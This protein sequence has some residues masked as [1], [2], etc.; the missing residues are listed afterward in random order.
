[1]AIKFRKKTELFTFYD[2]KGKKIERETEVRFDPLTGETSRL[3]YDAGLAITPPD[4][5]EE[6]DKTKGA[7]CP[8][9]PENIDTMTPVFPN[10]IAEE[11]RI[12]EGGAVV[13]PNLFPYSK[14]NGVAVFSGDHYVRLSEFTPQLIVNAFKAAQKYIHKVNITDTHAK[15]SSINWNYLPLSGGSIIHPHLHIIVSDSGTNYQTAVYEKA[16]QFEMETGTKYF[17]AL[18]ETEKSLGERWIADTGTVSWL[19]TFAPKSHNDYIG[20]FNHAFSIVD[21]QET[22]WKHF[23]KGLQ[24]IFASLTEQGFAS[25]NFILSVDPEGKEP[26]HVRLIPRLALGALD[27]SDINFFQALHQEPLT[28]KVPEEITAMARLH[29]E[30]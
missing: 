6:A 9:C 11:G 21:I 8:F 5:T 16:R 10:M 14:H 15:F 12:T 25:F 4:Y 24:S 3:V 29:F 26:V 27:T 1:M 23:A 20:I 2:S 18:Y 19:H 28:Y 30:N 17:A 22:D 7:N 13:F